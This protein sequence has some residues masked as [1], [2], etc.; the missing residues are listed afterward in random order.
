MASYNLNWVLGVHVCFRDLDFIIMVEGE[1][2]MAP[3]TVR[4]LHSTGLDAIA[5]AL[6]ELLLHTPKAHAPRSSL[7]LSFDYGRFEHQLGGF[8]GP[9]P[10]REDLC[11]LTF[12][13]ANVTM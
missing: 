8:L 13:F 1:L 6:E 3:A 12:L 11:C 4:P 9:R 7:L 2:A 5:E 10:S